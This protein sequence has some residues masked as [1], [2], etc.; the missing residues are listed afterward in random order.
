M[1]DADMEQS[2]NYDSV[3]YPSYTHP[4]THPNR[5]AVIGTLFGLK[6]ADVN[7]CQVLELGCGNGSNLVPMAWGLPNSKFVGIDLAS[8]PI[9]SGQQMIG[10]L[11]MTNI[12][13]IHG[14]ISEIN[15][16]GT[17]FDYIIAHGLYSWVPVEVQQRLLAT[18]RNLLSEQGIAFIS[19]NALPGGHLRS[20]LRE[21]ML[22]HV[23]GL[24]SPNERIQQSMALVR[25][26][27]HAQDT[28]DEY[29]LWLKSELE[30]IL[31][32][33]EGHLFHDELGDLN[34]PLYFTT[35]IER[36]AAH[37]LQFLGEA[38]YFE[39]FDHTFSDPVRK[40]LA[41]LAANR[42]LRE[43]YLDF[44]K[45]RRFRQTLLCRREACL[46]KEPQP[47]DV[48]AFFVSSAAACANG[49]I[50]FRAGV[51]VPFVSPK[52]AK[53]ET[54]L[55]VG[56]A[57]LAVLAAQWP[58]PLAFDDLI[59]QAKHCLSKHSVSCDDQ[60]HVREQLC[61]FLLQLYSAAIVE[62]HASRPDI[63][64][65]VSD[66]PT[67]SP[68]ARWQAARGNCVT[69][70]LHMVVKVEDEIGKHLLL[71]LDGTCD[72]KTLLDKLWDLLQSKAVLV[73]SDADKTA[74]RH[75]LERNLAGNLE[76][77]AR[78]GLLVA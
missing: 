47:D 18:C 16:V 31:E 11:G 6:P 51:A 69:S 59:N 66:R 25:F 61:G 53:C 77:L 78:L 10:D 29:R 19:Y 65:Q 39:M 67:A 13:L 2:T 28:Q 55:P 70:V 22:F 60:P 8:R 48:K 24:A 45:C 32:H 68:I 44:L 56:K 54:D 40:T 76:K 17:R 72:R 46:R 35:F 9:A 52:G 75:D 21:M 26:L 20:M 43:Q 3:L 50:D 42:I 73:K 36:A 74:A 64:R 63:A 37:Q 33:D 57:A 12:N 5:L 41:E 49:A 1:H 62:F 23:R 7:H 58:V 27:A 14:D 38:D 34:E 71:W 15:H 4:Q 30:T